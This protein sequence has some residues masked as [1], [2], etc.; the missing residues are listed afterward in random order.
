MLEFTALACNEV[1]SKKSDNNDGVHTFLDLSFNFRL[2]IVYVKS[3]CNSLS[4]IIRLSDPI[5]IWNQ[6]E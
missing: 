5:T 6:A 3:I 1:K 4:H 2:Y